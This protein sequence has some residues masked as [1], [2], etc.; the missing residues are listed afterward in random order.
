MMGVA[1]PPSPT[2][3]RPTQPLLRKPAGYAQ[4]ATYSSLGRLWAYLDAAQRSGRKLSVLR[5]DDLAACRRRIAGHTLEGAGL[6]LDDA[7]VLTALEDG[8]EPHPALLALLGGDAGPL[9]EVLNAAYCLRLDFV[10]AL[11]RPRDLI[12]RPEFVYQPR[13]TAPPLQTALPS[14]L[15]LV[16]RRLGRDELRFLLY[17]ACGL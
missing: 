10:L 3:T 2:L 5:G 17:G 11:T 9:R 12:V 13:V 6:L 16:A 14:D 7:R 1:T 15:P 8:L 4:L